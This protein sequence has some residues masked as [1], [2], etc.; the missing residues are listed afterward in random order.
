MSFSE[1]FF[2]RL[3]NLAAALVRQKTPYALGMR[4]SI[5]DED[6]LAFSRT[7]YSYLARGSSVEEAVSRVRLTLS[8]N[9]QRQWMIGVP[10]LYTSLSAPATGFVSKPGTPEIKEHQPPIEVSA[11]P[12]AEGAFQ[13]RIDEL[14]QLGDY[15]TGNNRPR[16]VTIHGSGGQGKT[17]LA[18]EAVERFTYAWPGGVWATTLENLPGREVF[19]SDLARFLGIATQEIHDPAEVEREVLRHLNQRRT[20]IVLDNAETLIEAVRAGRGGVTQLSQF[21]QQLAGPTVS[22]LVTSREHLG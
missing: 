20:V 5:P 18:R 13:G 9:R 10:V 14:I 17:A 11:L 12:R 2:N 6:A 22:L 21:I 1:G 19:V 7:F 16:L 3:S 8:R 4:F 15:L